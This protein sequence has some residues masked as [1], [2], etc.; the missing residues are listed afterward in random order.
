MVLQSF[1]VLSIAIENQR[2]PRRVG[3]QLGLISVSLTLQ[4]ETGRSKSNN[5]KL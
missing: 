3:R 5:Y 4:M 2:C 1:R